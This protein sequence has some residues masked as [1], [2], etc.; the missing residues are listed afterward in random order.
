M[1]SVASGQ[2]VEHGHVSGTSV[3]GRAPAVV[4]AVLAVLATLLAP[5]T[6][7]TA[8][9][10]QTV[11]G[12]VTVP[13]GVTAEAVVV[14]PWLW[15]SLEGEPADWIPQHEL[16]VPLTTSSGGYGYTLHLPAG[17]WVVQIHDYMTSVNDLFHPAATS[18]SA[19]TEVVVGSAPVTL[20]AVALT[21]FSSIAGV[22]KGPAGHSAERVLVQAHAVVAGKVAVDESGSAGTDEDGAYRIEYLP[23]GVYRLHFVPSEPGVAP[24]WFAGAGKAPVES[25]ALA[26]DIVLAHSTELDQIDVVLQTGGAVTGKVTALGGGAVSTEVEVR[27][28]EAFRNPWDGTGPEPDPNAVFWREVGEPASPAA[29]GTY[30]IQELPPGRYRI[31]VE[32]PNRVWRTAFHPAVATKEA[33]TD[34]QVHA[35]RTTTGVNITTDRSGSVRGSVTLPDGVAASDV[36]V[37]LSVQPSAGVWTRVDETFL[38][39]DGSYTFGS[40]G[41]GTYKVAFVDARAVAGPREHTGIVIGSGSYDVVVNSTLVLR[42]STVPP[43]D[44]PTT[45]P[46]PRPEPTPRITIATSPRL[47][48]TA[49][50]GRSVRVTRGTYRPSTVTVK[51]RWYLRSKSGKVVR[52]KGATKPKVKLKKSWVGRKLRA[53]VTVTRSGHRKVVVTTKWSTKVAR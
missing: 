24:G 20:S 16:E 38:V 34:V 27:A 21:T 28:Y 9:T 26:T 22:V 8:A 18:A 15:T 48:G 40:V 11:T 45:K 51:Y 50:A 2:V 29:D 6:G 7:A 30:R 25:S 3:R 17:R 52:I 37:T 5:V 32:D 49:R 23:P 14:T 41:R 42:G 47:K 53:Q 4:V 12:Q 43:T 31:G 33:G 46:T 44:T 19:A 10:T 35:A 13:A 1:G 36:R 39:A